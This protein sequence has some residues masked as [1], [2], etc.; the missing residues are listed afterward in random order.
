MHKYTQ[1]S[2]FIQSENFATDTIISVDIVSL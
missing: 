1:F 2:D